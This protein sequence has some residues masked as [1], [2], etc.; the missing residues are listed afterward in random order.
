MESKELDKM[1]EIQP[2][3]EVIKTCSKLESSRSLNTIHLS[4]PDY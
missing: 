1:K 4:A 2:W 3:S